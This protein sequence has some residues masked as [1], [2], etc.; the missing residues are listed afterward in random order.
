MTKD[1]YNRYSAPAPLMGYL[2]QCRYA[3]YESIRKIRT[4]VEFTVTI[5]TLDDVIFDIKDKPRESL[6][7]KHNLI[8]RANLTDYS[9]ELWKTLRIWS[10]GISSRTIDPD[11]IFFLITTSIS[12]NNTASSF[13]K[14]ESVKRNIPKAVRI[15]NEVTKKS[16]N[17][18]H[19]EYYKAFNT[20]SET[21]KEN[22][23]S[24]VF[25][26]D[27]SPQIEDLD[28]LLREELYHASQKKHLSLFLEHLEGWWFRR[29]INFIT[30]K[31][32]AILSQEIDAEINIIREGFKK[33]DLPF[34]NEIVLATINKE[35]YKHRTFYKQLKMI[36]MNDTSIYYAILN[37]FR[38]FEHRSKWARNDLLLIGEMDKYENRLIE[39]WDIR[40]SRMKDKIGDKAAKEEKIKAAKLLYEW[41]EDYSLPIRVSF[42]DSFLTSGSYQ[43]LSERKRI[44][45]HPDFADLLKKLEGESE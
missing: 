39:K 37:Y 2:Y 14:C 3:L 9:T 20:L 21:Q 12:P 45:W 44:G 34:D 8:N 35:E 28:N 4:D 1:Y 17:K 41:I 16:K 23:L 22:L 5:E 11:T 25:V 33:D 42:D 6:Q 30:K 15:L 19:K 36:E 10:E 18:D 43:M 32:K 31:K 29:I 26:M 7:M 27:A 40:F 38:A 24:R 13:L